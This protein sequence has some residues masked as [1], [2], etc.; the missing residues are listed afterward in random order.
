MFLCFYMVGLISLL[1]N[2][3]YYYRYPALHF[4]NY[5][6]YLILLWVNVKISSLYR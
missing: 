1:T 2:L 4:I 6:V 5:A 3:F